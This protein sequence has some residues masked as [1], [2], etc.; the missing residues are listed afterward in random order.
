MQSLPSSEQAVKW[1]GH[2]WTQA[3]NTARPSAIASF[4]ACDFSHFLTLELKSSLGVSCMWEP[5]LLQTESPGR[6]CLGGTL[7]A[8]LHPPSLEVLTREG[9]RN[10]EP[11]VNC[12]QESTSASHQLMPRPYLI[13][14]TSNR[15]LWPG[16]RQLS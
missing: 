2:G 9:R 7:S 1:V 11:V 6:A 13:S 15:G 12:I 3:Q 16:N 8:V 5:A 10:L 14:P 4:Y